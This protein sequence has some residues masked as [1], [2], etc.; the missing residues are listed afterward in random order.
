MAAFGKVLKDDEIW[1][2][3]DSMKRLHKPREK[4]S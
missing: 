3:V 1:A 4:S 2:I